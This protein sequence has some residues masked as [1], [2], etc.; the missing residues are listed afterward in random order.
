MKIILTMIATLALTTTLAFSQVGTEYNGCM[1]FK[2]LIQSVVDVNEGNTKLD[3]V[4]FSLNVLET[5]AFITEVIKIIGPPPNNWVIEEITKI[6]IIIM[7]PINSVIVFYN[8]DGCVRNRAMP[9]NN[10]MLQ[11]VFNSM[12]YKID[13]KSLTPIKDII[14]SLDIKGKSY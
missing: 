4:L 5:K 6:D 9:M 10:G 13:N 12:N 2:D 14:E 8:A 1:N 3:G 7:N 11:D